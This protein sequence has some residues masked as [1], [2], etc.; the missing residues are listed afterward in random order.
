[1]PLPSSIEQVKHPKRCAGSDSGD[2]LRLAPADASGDDLSSLSSYSLKKSLRIDYLGNFPANRRPGW[3]KELQGIT[4]DES[5]W[6]IAQRDKLWKFPKEHDLN[7]T[8]TKPSPGQGILMVTIPDHLRAMG[9]DHMGDIDC[10][11]GR[12]YIPLENKRRTK[13]NMLMVFDAGSMEFLESYPLSKKYVGS[14]SWV[15]LDRGS[16]QIF[17]SNNVIGK[18]SPIMIYSEVA[19]VDVGRLKLEGAFYPRDGDGEPMTIE[20]VQGG[21]ISK[22][23]KTLFL[24]S[25]MEEGGILAFDLESKRLIAHHIIDYKRRFPFY[26][27]LQGVTIWPESGHGSK[28]FGGNLHVIMIDNDPC[29][30]DLYLKHF[31]ISAGI[32]IGVK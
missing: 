9:Y 31:Q 19:G 27:E 4:H 24:I 21:V 20:R 3:S 23:G 13:G 22:D 26:E 32:A 5:S 30:D 16:G 17:M 18:G 2:G 8:V 10:W 12:I 7:A 6:F 14:A 1:M 29:D 15:A 25:D 28:L 11:D